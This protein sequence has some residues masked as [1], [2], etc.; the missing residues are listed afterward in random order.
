[1]NVAFARLF[2]W[3]HL[4]WITGFPARSEAQA[5]ET[6]AANAFV[7]YL[8]FYQRFVS[9][10]G[11]TGGGCP[12][13]PNCSRFAVLAFR[14]YAPIRAF[15][16][17]AD[18]LMR[19]GRDGR[20]YA[21]TYQD[22]GFRTL[23]FPDPAANVPFLNVARTAVFA[24]SDS[25][26]DDDPQLRFG[27]QLMNKGLHA[28][29]LLI[30]SRYLIESPRAVP[31]EVF[32]NYL[33]CLRATDNPENALY[34]Y[35]TTRTPALRQ[36]PAVLTEVGQC[37]FQLKNYERAAAA[38]AAARA[39]LDPA[40]EQ[41]DKLTM[42]RGVAAARRMDWDSARLEFSLI[43]STSFYAA[44]ARRNV[45]LLAPADRL[46]TRN[47]GLAGVLGVVPG[48]GYLYTGHRQTALAA[49][50]ING[51]FGWATVST[52]Q[53]QN[54]GLGALVGVVSLGFYA[55]NIQGSVRSARRFNQ[56]HREEVAGRVRLDVDNR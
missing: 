31:A 20:Q 50:L 33:A 44:N 8:S 48:L 10:S 2:V 35:E 41:A 56:R 4:I 45:D 49:L 38:F 43:P 26:R 52:F 16:L 11:G 12:S 46:P 51:L 47:P 28:Q 15:G 39:R 3:T 53:R 30:W 32:V 40:S 13:Y 21:V 19:C 42:L 9:G 18:R 5:L 37:W 25:I 14:Q 34:E 6:P 17:T 23:D 36:D 1:M 22:G 24:R 27:K 54:Y 29:A 7:D 55:G